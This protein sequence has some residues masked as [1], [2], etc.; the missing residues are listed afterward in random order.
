M[1]KSNTRLPYFG[2]LGAR[3]EEV[4]R[5]ITWPNVEQ[6]RKIRL[7]CTTTVMKRI[8]TYYWIDRPKNI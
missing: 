3:F 2:G 8:I 1:N 5:I 6:Q 7:T 4:D